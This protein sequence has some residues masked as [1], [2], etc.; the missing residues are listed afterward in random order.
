MDQITKAKMANML[1]VKKEQEVYS[2][3]KRICSKAAIE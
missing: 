3:W 1:M 2:R